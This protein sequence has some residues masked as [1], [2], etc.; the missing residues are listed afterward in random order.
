[1]PPWVI[2]IITVVATILASSGFWSIV[3]YRM[4]KHDA[5]DAMIKGLG[6]DRIISLGMEY[7]ERGNWITEDEYENL[8]VYLYEPYKSMNGNGSA[9][10]V[11]A[12]VKQRLSIVKL[13]PEGY[14]DA[15]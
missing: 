6:H 7:L 2:T 11:I 4:Q 15:R 8:I 5:R 9:E 10:R 3:L 1:M 14:E 12:E 13:P